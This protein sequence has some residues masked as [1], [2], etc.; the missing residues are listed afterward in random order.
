MWY[1][2]TCSNYSESFMHKLLLYKTLLHCDNP[3]HLLIILCLCI[4]HTHST[5][6]HVA[7]P[8]R[9]CPRFRAFKLHVTHTASVSLHHIISSFSPTFMRRPDLGSPNVALLTVFIIYTMNYTLFFHCFLA[10]G[11][12]NVCEI[13]MNPKLNCEVMINCE[14]V[15][16]C[17]VNPKLNLYE[18]IVT[19]P[20]PPK[21]V[22]LSLSLSLSPFRTLCGTRPLFFYAL[23]NNVL[24]MKIN[25]LHEEVSSSS[26]KR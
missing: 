19:T 9:I 26:Q 17:R 11:R 12:E 15:C 5:S 1:S 18:A 2:F 8:H 22:A 4:Y 20:T 14:E 10:N 3:T 16:E 6:H 24:R 21:F 13:R 23:Q 7:S 25:K